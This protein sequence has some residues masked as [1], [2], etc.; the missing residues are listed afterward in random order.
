MGGSFGV[1]SELGKGSTFWIELP[2]A[3]EYD[4]LIGN[5]LFENQPALMNQALS[6]TI[7][8]IEDN[9]AN[10][11]LVEQTLLSYRPGM[12]L[13]YTANGLD[14]VG[15]AKTHMPQLILLDLN[16][17]DAHGSDVQQQLT[18]DETHVK[19]PSS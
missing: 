8:Y 15:L 10:V 17:P 9:I 18:A 7:L 4:M 11:E 5:E 19:Y 12:K 2:L 13:V 16:L 3:L 1:E 6:G 14:A